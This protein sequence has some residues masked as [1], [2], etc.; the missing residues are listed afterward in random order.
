MVKGT[1]KRMHLCEMQLKSFDENYKLTWACVI[2]ETESTIS[3]W[4]KYFFNQKKIFKEIACDCLSFK[5][6][7]AYSNQVFF[8]RNAEVNSTVPDI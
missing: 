2:H 5:Y 4:R 3:Q 6:D 7:E 8:I 1:G